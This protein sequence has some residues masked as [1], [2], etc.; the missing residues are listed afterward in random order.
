VNK[1]DRRRMTVLQGLALTM[2]LLLGYAVAE[3]MRGCA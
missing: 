1:P 2:L 3:L